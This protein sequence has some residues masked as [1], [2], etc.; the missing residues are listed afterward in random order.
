MTTLFYNEEVMSTSDGESILDTLLR[1]DY[2]IPYGCRSG[3]CQSCLMV[4]DRGSPTGL[5]Q[6]G[7]S[8]AQK[9]LGYFLSCQCIPS[10]VMHVKQPD[11]EALRVDAVVVDKKMLAPNVIRLR[12]KSDLIY[13]AGQ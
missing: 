8:D 5:A 3:V 12:L 1:H 7:L 6:Q 11:D 4:A 2:V 10:E 9:E 13:Q